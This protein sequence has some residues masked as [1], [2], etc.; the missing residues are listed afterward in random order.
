MHVQV[1]TY[2]MHAQVCMYCMHVQVCMYCMHVQVCMYCMHA[3]VCMYCMHAQVCMYCMHVQVC[4]YCM[5]AQVCMYCM[6]AQKE[7]QKPLEHT[8][9]HVI[10][11][12]FLGVCPQT[13]PH[14]VFIMGPTFRICPGSIQSS[15]WPWVHCICPGSLQSSQWPR[16]PP[17]L[18]VTP[19]PSNPLGDP[20]SLQS[21]QWPWVHCIL[22]Y[23]R[24]ICINICF[25]IVCILWFIPQCTVKALCTESSNMAWIFAPQRLANS[26]WIVFRVHPI[27][28][29]YSKSDTP[30]WD[31]NAITKWISPIHCLLETFTGQ[32]V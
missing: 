12:N 6:Y 24:C 27:M 26:A 17:I 30:F 18:S 9:E 23:K 16:V 22:S 7:S 3:Q 21:S 10:A 8:S 29:E 19:G 28:H 32:G 4:M 31:K 5:H 25:N 11:Q 14:T 2:C 20:G 1:C 15:Q 13:S